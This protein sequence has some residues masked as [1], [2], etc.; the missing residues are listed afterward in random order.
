MDKGSSPE[1]NNQDQANIGNISIIY[2]C[3]FV[4]N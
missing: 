1:L 3:N 2:L 4:R